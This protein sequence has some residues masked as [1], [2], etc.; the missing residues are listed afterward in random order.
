MVQQIK[1]KI[2]LIVLAIFFY[3][4][5]S[6]L[7]LD[8]PS[9]ESFFTLFSGYVLGLH[10]VYGYLFNSDI[11]T[12]GWN[13]KAGETPIIRKGLFFIGLIIMTSVLSNIFY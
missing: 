12:V 1:N 10:F 4:L 11:H 5:A 13:Y 6:I 7:W 2:L 9:T 8:I 3:I